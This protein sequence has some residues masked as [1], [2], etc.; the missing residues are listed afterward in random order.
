MTKATACI[1]EG[2]LGR[3]ERVAPARVRRPCFRICVTHTP[4]CASIARPA[5]TV[6]LGLKAI[7]PSLESTSLRLRSFGCMLA[8]LPRLC[9]SQEP[10]DAV[11]RVTLHL[12]LRLPRAWQRR[13]WRESRGGRARGGGR[14]CRDVHR[15]A[16]ASSQTEL[17]TLHALSEDRR[18]AVRPRARPATRRRAPAPS[19]GDDEC[20]L[21][22]WRPGLLPGG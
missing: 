4:L 22:A 17:R 3:G 13:G 8:R 6:R 14:A 9:A 11:P 7:A 20:C 16:L 5:A 2:S 10:S 21:G 15:T 19:D 18:R 1:A 12:L